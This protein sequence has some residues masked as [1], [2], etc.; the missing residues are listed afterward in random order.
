MTQNKIRTLIVDD[1][2]LARKS[3]SV[4]LE[5]FEDYEVVGECDNGEDAVEAIHRLAPDLVFLDIQMPEM[6]GFEVLQ[7]L[8]VKQLPIVVFVTAY[9]EFAIRAFE[10]SAIDYVMKPF[11]D[12]RLIQTLNRIREH[13]AHR[14]MGTLSENLRAFLEKQSA[15][16]SAADLQHSP[17]RQYMKRIS[18]KE[19][20][21]I[22]LI[23]IDDIWWIQADG[24]YSHVYTENQS[25]FADHALGFLEKRLDPDI[26][27]RINRNTMVH[28][29]R[30]AALEPYSHGEYFVILKNNKRLKLSRTYRQK[31]SQILG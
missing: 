9:N 14:H 1:E 25:Y 27:Q 5:R 29:N 11:D 10:V 3:I 2:A 13:A 12:D 28:L 30:I 8:E 6:N 18:I 26:F 22:H 20:R 7:Q 31:L 16:D 23:D 15:T 19:N 4:I 24:N 17:A 21:T